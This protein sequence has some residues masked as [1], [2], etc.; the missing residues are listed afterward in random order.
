MPTGERPHPRWLGAVAWVYYSSL[1]VLLGAELTQVW[2][3]RSG[4]QG[5]LEEG[6]VRV[7]QEEHLLRV[8]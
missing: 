5:P 1:I 4:Y 2:A 8:P 6:P 3:N 7:V